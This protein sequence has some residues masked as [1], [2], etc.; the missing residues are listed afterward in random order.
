MRSEKKSRI[1]VFVDEANINVSAAKN[2]NKAVDCHKF[3]KYLEE[4]GDKP[5]EIVEMIIYAGLPPTMAEF[6]DRRQSKLSYIQ[7]LRSEGFLVCEKNGQPRGTGS[8]KANVDVIMAIDA[9]DLTLRIKPDAVILVT[10]DAD[11]AHLALTIRRQG[12]KVEVASLPKTLSTELKTSANTVI[13]LTDLLK[14]FEPLRPGPGLDSLEVIIKNSAV[15]PEVY[16]FGD[17]AQSQAEESP[18]AV[19]HSRRA[20]RYA[21]N[22]SVLRD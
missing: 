7:W 18:P 8:Y 20:A 15:Q 6:N 16:D 11:F 21:S 10:G 22:N 19:V 17:M 9:L 12:I 13:D 1:L 5:R 4:Y 2:H 3:R 14:D